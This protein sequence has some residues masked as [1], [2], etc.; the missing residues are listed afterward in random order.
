[1]RP[2][3]FSGRWRRLKNRDH[4]TVSVDARLK[5]RRRR[6]VQSQ[7]C[8]RNCNFVLPGDCRYARGEEGRLPQII[9]HDVG[10]PDALY[11]ERRALS[12]GRRKDMLFL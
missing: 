1:M 12:R 5:S 10:A 8:D 4:D 6:T 7:L 9:F 3:A 11:R 2:D